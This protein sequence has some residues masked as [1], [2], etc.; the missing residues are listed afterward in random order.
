MGVRAE[1]RVEEGV[2]EGIHDTKGLLKMIYGITL[3]QKL[4]LSLFLM[5]VHVHVHVCMHTERQRDKQTE[6]ETE[7]DSMELPCNN[8]I[9]A[10]TGH[11]RLT[12]K[13]SGR[14]GS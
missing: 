1:S 8:K 6:T 2:W 13:S 11:Q 3:P 7:T 5:Y 12:K 9:D 4:L 14:Y 10:P